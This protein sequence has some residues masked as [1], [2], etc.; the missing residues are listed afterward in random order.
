[1]PMSS[2]RGW[3]REHRP[4]VFLL[5]CVGPAVTTGTWTLAMPPVRGEDCDTTYRVMWHLV[6]ALQVALTAR[7]ALR[8]WRSESKRSKGTRIIHLLFLHVAPIVSLASLPLTYIS[9]GTLV[10]TRG[11]FWAGLA[12][13]SNHL[14]YYFWFCKPSKVEG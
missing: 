13:L 12:A 8:I 9:Y 2:L 7:V 1:M 11:N 14:L 6:L 4:S 5:V 10:M 3:H